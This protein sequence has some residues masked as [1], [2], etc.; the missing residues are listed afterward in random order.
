MW[1][2]SVGCFPSNGFVEFLVLWTNFVSSSLTKES[3]KPEFTKFGCYKK[4][5]FV[6]YEIEIS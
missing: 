6:A 2:Y 1:S 3:D 5:F 4:L